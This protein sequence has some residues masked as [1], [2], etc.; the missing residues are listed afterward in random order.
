MAEKLS[1]LYDN[2]IGSAK[3]FVRW[4]DGTCIEAPGQRS[5]KDDTEIYF[6]F[7]DDI[8]LE[9]QVLRN[10]FAIEQAIW[11]ARSGIKKYTES[12]MK[13]HSLWK[14]DKQQTVDRFMRKSPSTADFERKI[15]SY[16]K[17]ASDVESTSHLKRVDFICITSTRL[18]YDV[19]EEALKMVQE[20]GNAMN[21]QDHQRSLDMEHYIE[22]K[23]SWLSAEPTTLEELKVVLRTI[24]EVRERSIEFEIEYLDLEERYRIRTLNDI[25]PDDDM[26]RV[27]SLKNKWRKLSLHAENVDASLTE[28]KNKFMETTQQDVKAF[29]EEVKEFKRRFEEEGPARGDIDLDEGLKLMKEYKSEME[30]MNRKREDLVKAQKLFDLEIVSY[31]E[32]AEVDDHIKKLSDIYDVYNQHMHNLNAF[33]NMLWED[34]DVSNISNLTDGVKHQLRKLK[35]LRDMP[36]YQLVEQRI[37]SFDDSLPLIRDLRSNALRKRHWDQIMQVTGYNFE[38]DP[39][40]FTVSN[41]FEMRLDNYTD[42]IQEIVA[43]ATKE[44]KIE[45][46]LKKLQEVWREQRLTLHQYNRGNED[47]GYVIKNVEDITA[48]L[49]EWGTNLQSMLGAPFVKPF[50]E[51]VRQWEAKLTRV[52]EVI[53][54]WMHVQ[55]KWIYLEAIFVG[56]DDI[57]HQLPEQ[58]KR[59]DRVDKQFIKLMSDTA[60]NTSV[61]DACCAEGRLETLQQIGEELEICQKNLTDYLDT[62]RLAFPRFFFISDEEL[63]SILGSS[64]PTS[65]QEHMLKLFDNCAN[66]K[67]GRGNKTIIGMRS[68]ESEQFDFQNAVQVEGPV[69]EWMT[70]VEKEMRNTLHAISKEGVFYYAK[71]ERK[72]WILWCL[73][74]TAIL[75]SQTWWTWEV[76]DSFRRVQQGDKHAMIDF[77][78]KLSRQLGDLTDM[79]RSN[80][81]SLDRKKINAMI[82]IEVHARD[83]VNGFVRDSILDPKEFA[84][85]SQLRF[86]WDKRSDDVLICQCTGKFRYGYEYMGLNGRLVVT[87]LTDRAYMTL[88]TALSYNLG[89]SAAGPAGTGKTETVKDLA[90]SMALL[91]IVFNCGEGLDYKAMGAIFSGLVQCGAWGCFDEF[92]RIEA[93]VLSVISSQLRQIQEALKNGVSRFQFE[94]KDLPLDQRCGIFITMNPGYAGRTELPDNLKALF[95]PV[96]MVVPDL[97]QICEIM[98]FS[99]GFDTARVLAKKMT[100]LYGL[101]KEQLSKQYHYDFGLRAIKSVL[102]MAGSLKWKEPEKSEQVLLM[103]ALRD[104]NLPKFVANDV[105]LFMGLLSDLFPGLEAESVRY[106]SFNEAVE[107]DLA[108]NGYQVVTSPGGQVDKV[109]QLYETMMTR[110]TTMVVGPTG[111]GKSVMI[112]T[113]A[114]AQTKLDLPTKLHTLNPKAQ[115]VSELY[116]MLDPDT[117]EWTDG[118]L[119]HIFRDVNKPLPEGKNEQHY[120]VFD[121]DVDA[122]WVE[123]MNSVMDDNKLLTLPNG[124]RIRLQD[125]CKL[126]FEVYD[127]QYASPATISRCGMVYVDTSSIGVD[128]YIWRWCNSRQEEEAEVLRSLFT[129]YTRPCLDYVLTG[130]DGETFQAALRTCIP[131]TELNLVSQLCCLLESVLPTSPPITDPQT[132]EAIFIFATVWSLGGAVVQT[133]DIKDR[134]RF[135]AFVKELSGLTTMDSET[136]PTM[137]LPQKSLYEFCFDVTDLRWRAWRSLVPEYEPPEDGEFSSILVP[138]VDT[139]RSTWVLGTL[140]QNRKRVLFVGESGTA[141]TVTINKYLNTLSAAEFSTLGLPFS[142]RTTSMDVQQS[143]EENIEKRTKETYGPSM[144]KKLVVYIDD[145]NMPRVDKYGTQQPIALL[146]FLVEKGG[147]FD[148]GKDL[149]WKKIKDLQ[150]VAS[151]GPPGGARNNLDPRFVSL[152]NVFEIQFPTNENVSAI[153]DTILKSIVSNLSEEIQDSAAV[154]TEK[155]LEL[156]YHVLNSLPPTPQRF[157]YIFNLR[158]L[159]RVF[160]GL[161]LAT[162]DKIVTTAQFVRLWRNECL[163]IFHDRLIDDTD[164]KVVTDK[165]AEMVGSIVSDKDEAEEVLADPTIFGDFRNA[166]ES[167]EARIYEDLGGYADIKSIFEDIL[168][169]YNSKGH[170]M[171]L[172]FFDF[173]LEHLVRIHRILRL[174]M[175]HALLV[176]VGGSGKQSLSRL[177]AFTAGCEVFE[178]SLS[179]NYDESAFRE[180]LKSLYNMLG[181]ENK[182]MMF[183][184]TD[185]QVAAEDFLELVNNMLASGMVPAL[186]SE[187]EKDQAVNA[188]REEAGKKGVAQTKEACW[189][190]FVQKCRSNLHVVLA[191]SP[192]G[193]SLRVRCR[194]FPAMVNNCVIDWFDPWPSSALR[195]VAEVFLSDLNL[196]EGMR[197]PI[198]EHV[199]GVHLTVRNYSVTF[200]QELRRHNYVTPKSYL[201]FIGNYKRSLTNQRKYVGEQSSRLDA[202]LSKLVQAAEEVDRMQGELTEKKKEVEQSRQRVNELLEQITENREKVETKQKQA[203]DREEEVKVERENIKKE[204]GEA[205]EELA[206]AEPVLQEAREALNNL[207]SSHVNEMRSFAN[208]PRMARDVGAC[209]ASLKGYKSTEWSTVRSMMSDPSFLPSIQDKSRF[210][211]DKELN[212]KRM[213]RVHKITRPSDKDK[214]EHRSEM[215]REAQRQT[216]AGAG[217]LRWVFAMEDYY[218]VLRNVKPKRERVQ[219]MEKDLA[220]KET[221]LDEIQ[222]EVQDLNSQLEQ[223]NRD[224]Q[225]RTQELQ[226]L[227]DQANTMERRLDAASRLIEGLGSERSRWTGEIGELE[228]RKERLVGDCLLASSFLSYLGAFTA[229]YRHRMLYDEWQHDLQQRGVPLT[230]PFKVQ[231][232]LSNDV[233]MAKWNSEGLPNDDLSLQNGIL[234]TRSSRFPLCIDPQMQAVKWIKNKEGKNLEGRIKT[235]GDSDDFLKQLELAIQ[236]G[237]PFLLENLGEYIDPVINPILERE[238][239]QRAGD[240]P[241]I[242]IGDKEVEWDP[243]FRLYMTTK[244]TNPHYSPE[245]AGKTVIINFGVTQQGLQDQLLNITVRHEREELEQ[246]RETLVAEM[247]ENRT[248]LKQLED[249]L[250]HELSSAQ[251]MILDNQDLINTLENTKSKAAEISQKLE[252][253]KRTAEDL[254]ATRQRYQP[255]AKRGSIL[256]FVMA[257]LSALNSMYQYSLASYIEVFRLTLRTSKR[258]PSLE[259]RV[260]NI[261]EAVTYDVYNYTCYGLFEQHKLLLSFQMTIKILEADGQIDAEY[262]DFFMK[263]NLE[264]EKSPS[265]KPYSWFPDQGWED[266]MRL[267]DLKQGST[268]L[269]GLA[270]SIEKDEAS[271]KA[272]YEAEKPEDAQLPDGYEDLLSRFEKMMVLRCLRVD[273]IT[274]AV[275]KFVT[276]HLGEKYVQ[277]PVLDFGYIYRSSAPLTPVVFVLS[278]G[279]DPANDIFKLGD[280]MGFKPGSKLKYMALGQGMG[281]KAKEMLEVGSQRG[282]WVMLQNCHLLPNWLEK[283]ER[284]LQSITN[285]HKDFRLWLTTDPTPQFPMG[286]LQMSLKVVTEPPNGL[287]LNMRSSYS[288]ISESDLAECPHTAFRPLVYVLSFFHAVVQERRKY[289]KLGWNVSYDF[290]ETDFRISMR[291]LSTYLTKAVDNND[292]SIPWQTLRY[293][294]GEAMYG[295]RVS[296]AYDRRVLTTYLEEY[297]GDF[298]F[299]TYQVFYFFQNDSVTY[300]IPETGPKENYTRVIDG[301]P[302][303]QSPEVFGLHPNADIS[304]YTAAAKSLWDG[305]SSLQSRHAGRADDKSQE[306]FIVNTASD[307]QRKIP[308][309]FDLAL[310]R[311]EMGTPT[312]VQTVLIQELERFNILASTMASSLNTL[313]RAIAGEVGMGSDVE[314]TANALLNGEL[315]SLWAGLTPATEKK[316]GSWVAWFI[317]RYRYAFFFFFSFSFRDSVCVL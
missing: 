74:M 18:L 90:K 232:L 23:R 65:I 289:G 119:S 46:E 104:M 243:N 73:G 314:A 55:R 10:R 1:R 42:S 257:S 248:L 221:E 274:I 270:S 61:L 115:G 301:L 300:S 87:E 295:G 29:Q 292:E 120:I 27:F 148:R 279:A 92:N 263:G 180:D 175:G 160:E 121:G 157:H 308:E 161:S 130:Y 47:R 229:E 311:K 128:P 299:D 39:K 225:Q 105:P 186:F 246:Q 305:L 227:T 183:L 123:N 170:N 167:N 38:Q 41:L 240:N 195:S 78:K 303:V 144:G 189:N 207:E 21:E 66:L 30:E 106:E 151:M 185:T 309:P 173:A 250:L 31:P 116:G 124:E 26:A 213:S 94:G 233:E 88:T 143:I 313:Q 62:K 316:L 142:S 82:I 58:A 34:I 50:Y 155:T 228:Q 284:T 72:E 294:I 198:V 3:A 312:P 122:E 93:E 208:P 307:I 188:V 24:S 236:Y 86:Y 98:L 146:R 286:I 2:V 84:W 256:F 96:T 239:I 109:V 113:L 247:S 145:L 177:A 43:G 199:V 135:D 206:A 192:A 59:F 112:E 298:L 191:M 190:Y 48:L 85:E 103:R 273:R 11:S 64:D 139:V 77:S 304:Y 117:R 101:A 134:E 95:R 172:V 223:L 163:R 238:V 281:G 168:E 149:N 224:H 17:A 244:L 45:E 280:E 162:P 9:K 241:M 268:P 265:P 91:C 220:N 76:E 99:E 52:S 296:D 215:L 107:Q 154:I 25:Q 267:V 269:A 287:K 231:D 260:R 181:V 156:Y 276:T 226:E 5:P 264:L 254:D 266:L 159:S 234:T 28:T 68:A 40:S 13:N 219:R 164:R 252:Q 293:L 216:T 7:A 60:K 80:L 138:T 182:R 245:V 79:V 81:G 218:D 56:S 196:P 291:L 67:F 125:H 165:M 169:T 22:E 174:E 129:K 275:T 97:D 63:L 201:D 315:P 54:E 4:M 108:Q 193:H 187:E 71:M 140:L 89:G 83:I 35:D 272:V 127:L 184:F 147:L 209:V 210:D 14:P 158:D 19:K 152:F 253:S 212:D 15:W 110:H 302:M 278:P 178:I 153:Y 49:E 16:L 317:R 150:F 285:P 133:S 261:V 100:V 204:K 259:G 111:G 179:R 262:L 20:F 306:G 214:D 75:G 255:A 288:K 57:R 33:S 242:K 137:Q 197:E 283:L 222:R 32:L 290:N 12:W 176:G 297:L 53:E 8:Q 141:K 114:R 194:N 310:M 6:T 237:F 136:V 211:P 235:L 166:L 51:D 205:E 277:P 132:L 282:L 251:G 36:V 118:L 203:H 126:L 44:L 230:Y 202:G 200:H 249:T 258:D 102:S 171:N 37:Q 271:W 131:R 217:L 70:N 69:E